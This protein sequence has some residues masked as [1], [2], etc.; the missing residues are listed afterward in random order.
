MAFKKGQ[1]GNPAG[2]PK[3]ATT[4][5]RLSDYL[6]KDQVDNLVKKAYELA[7]TGNTDMIKFILDH[8]FG[9]APQA[10]DHTTNGKELPT[11]IFDVFSNNCD[12]ENN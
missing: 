5:P 4:K 2:K 8:N 3:G 6:S 11:P 10:L 1:S 12:K 9:K 7:A